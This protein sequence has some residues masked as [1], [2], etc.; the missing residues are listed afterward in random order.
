MGPRG[1]G[2]F[3]LRV[4]YVGEDIPHR[5][6]LVKVKRISGSAMVKSMPDGSCNSGRSSSGAR[7]WVLVHVSDL[8]W[9]A[10][11]RIEDEAKATLD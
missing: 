3:Q 11:H 5:Y 10:Y 1:A 7:R 9:R 4:L 2:A 8:P 6:R